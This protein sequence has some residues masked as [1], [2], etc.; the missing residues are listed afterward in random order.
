[1]TQ[2]QRRVLLGPGLP[3]WLDHGLQ[4]LLGQGASFDYWHGVLLRYSNVALIGVFAL[5]LALALWHS[6]GRQRSIGLMDS[7]LLALVALGG[8]LQIVLAKWVSGH[9]YQLPLALALL[10][11]TVRDAPR[12]PLTGLRGGSAFCSATQLDFPNTPPLRDASILGVF[13]W[14]T[15][16]AGAHV[17]GP[18]E[19][20]VTRDA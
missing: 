1:M 3:G 2:E 12:L 8:L 10:W 15:I 4:A 9:Y 6:Y 16:A 11:G 17:F 5:V 19:D 20:A 18:E 7:R 14:L 13:V